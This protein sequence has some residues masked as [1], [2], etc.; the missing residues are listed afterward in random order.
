MS[1][2]T[3]PYKTGSILALG[4]DPGIR[5]TGYAFVYK[6]TSGYRQVSHGTIET[7]TS[8]D[9]AKQ[10]GYIWDEL[11]ER[12]KF[13][14][15]EILCVENV[16]FNQ[17]KSTAMDTAK[18]IGACLTLGKKRNIRFI[19]SAKPQDIKAALTGR[20]TASKKL[21]MSMAEKLTGLPNGAL[22]THHTADAIGAAIMGHMLY[23]PKR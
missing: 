9:I 5:N 23:L 20:Q 10:L 15:P 16:Y 7:S 2:K 1:Q 12:I 19:C 3:T 4:I 21:M 11:D 6:T 8:W 22:R 17:N 18:V 14:E 13:A